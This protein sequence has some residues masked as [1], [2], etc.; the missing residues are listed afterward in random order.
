ME[1]DSGDPPSTVTVRWSATRPTPG[2]YQT[3]W[4]PSSESEPLEEERSVS[5][6]SFWTWTTSAKLPAVTCAVSVTETTVIVSTTSAR[7]PRPSPSRSPA[8]MDE[9]RICVVVGVT[10]S[11]KGRISSGK[12]GAK[13]GSAVPSSTRLTPQGRFTSSS[14]EGNGLEVLDVAK[15]AALSAPAGSVP[16]T[17][18]LTV[19]PDACWYD[20]DRPISAGK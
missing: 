13:T 3:S 8:S 10:W 9:Q 20:Q 5:W 7:S 17:L 18:T 12:V 15:T 4:N 6:R 19:P 2:A 1:S 14:D 16:V 11:G